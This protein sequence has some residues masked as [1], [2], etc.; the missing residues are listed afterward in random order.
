M[1]GS[2][3]STTHSTKLTTYLLL[4]PLSSPPHPPQSTLPLPPVTPTAHERSILRTII[5]TFMSSNGGYSDRCGWCNAYSP[6]VR[7]VEGNKFFLGH[8]N[9][10]Q[11]KSNNQRNI[12]IES[13]LPGGSSPNGGRSPEESE[14]ESDGDEGGG[15][16][17]KKQDR[18]MT[19]LEVQSQAKKTWELE[20]R[21]DEERSDELTTLAMETRREERSDDLIQH[22]AITDNLLLV[23][24]LLAPFFASLIAALPL[25]PCLWFNPHLRPPLP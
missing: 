21:L 19:A 6:R 25:L 4:A 7:Q 1:S 13:A 14:S 16:G 22:S 17:V 18:F 24:L 2:D 10:K 9:P 11:L 23:V 15:G 3:G 12:E 5:H 8:L 20:V